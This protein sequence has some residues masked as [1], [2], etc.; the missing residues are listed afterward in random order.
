[1][2][3]PKMTSAPHPRISP[4]VAPSDF[5][6]FGYLK[7]QLRKS[8]CDFSLDPSTVTQLIALAVD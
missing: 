8:K 1:M 3:G 7:D 2:E 4:E 5:Y 6:P